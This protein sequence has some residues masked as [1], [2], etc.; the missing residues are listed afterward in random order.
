MSEEP[1][2]PEFVEDFA[3]SLSE[4][5]FARMPSRV[6]SLLL[7]VPEESLTAREIAERLG[8]SPAAVSGAVRYL[9][10]MS[11]ARRFRVRGERVDRFGVG[12]EVWAPVFA[13][14]LQTYGPLQ[15]LCDRAVAAGDVQGRGAERV[16]ETGEFF[17]FLATEMAGVLER[18][19]ATRA[20][21]TA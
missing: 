10:Q 9:V 4:L 5:G 15:D 20:Q 21:D 1:T 2:V 8:V 3:G 19:R 7:A 18:W 17:A 14:E 6:F 13:M 12:E 11:L 16:A